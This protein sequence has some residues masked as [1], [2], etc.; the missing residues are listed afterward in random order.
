[1]VWATASQAEALGS[2]PALH[3][4]IFMNLRAKFSLKPRVL[5]WRKASRGNLHT[6]VKEFNDVF[7]ISNVHCAQL[8]GLN[9]LKGGDSILKQITEAHGSLLRISKTGLIHL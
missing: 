5:R 6:C 4:W 1:M 3:L 9:R 8:W 2:H 7:E